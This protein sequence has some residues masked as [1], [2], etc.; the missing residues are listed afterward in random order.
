MQR[1]VTLLALAV[2]AAWPTSASASNVV[3]DTARRWPARIVEVV[4]CDGSANSDTSR[5][6][7]TRQKVKK[8]ERKRSSRL[9]EREAQLVRSTIARW[10][11]EFAGHIEFREVR[12][13]QAPSTVVFRRSSRPSRCST[14]RIGYSKAQRW[15]HISLGSHC[16]RSG[17]SRG[18]TAGTIAH[19][20]LHAVGVYHEQQRRDRDRMIRIADTGKKGHQW[21]ASCTRVRCANQSV[22]ARPVGPYDFRSVMHYS[23][24]P[25]RAEPTRSGLRRLNA[26]KLPTEQVGQRKWLSSADKTGLR[27]LYP[28]RRG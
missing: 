5:A 11:A 27:R 6:A 7:C 2:A 15:K 25:G 12:D 9:D 23:L 28:L 4:I 21:T 1:Y 26:Q 3:A 18:T 8:G 22:A 20:M 19:E 24:Q 10:N 13:P 17:E 14:E 16:G